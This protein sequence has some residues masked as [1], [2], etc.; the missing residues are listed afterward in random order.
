MP[1]ANLGQVCR[2][3]S[4]LAVREWRRAWQLIPGTQQPQAIANAPVL[5]AE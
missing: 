4:D 5:K 3:G 2:E 1:G